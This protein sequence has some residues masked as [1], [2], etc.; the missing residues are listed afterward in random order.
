MPTAREEQKAG[1]E[2]AKT[3]EQISD[4]LRA[5]N[6]P[7]DSQGDPMVEIAFQ[8]HELIGLENFSNITVGPAVVRT[9]VSMNRPNPFTEKQLANIASAVNQIAQTVEERIVAEQRQIALATLDPS[10]VPAS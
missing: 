10:L 5:S 3:A 4:T 8:A 7:V 1:H 9:L 2:N 6:W